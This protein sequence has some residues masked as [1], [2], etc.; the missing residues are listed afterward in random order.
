ME[1]ELNLQQIIFKMEELT[2][3]QID[4]M[5]GVTQETKDAIDAKK[6]PCEF[7]TTK[8]ND[9]ITRVKILEKI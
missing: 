9:L 4:E 8:V 6:N 2:Q 3:E 7:L 1:Q 5:N